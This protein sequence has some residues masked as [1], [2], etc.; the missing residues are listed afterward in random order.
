MR[1]LSIGLKS[2]FPNGQC[3]GQ[4][5]RASHIIPLAC[6]PVSSEM[7]YYFAQ[8]AAAT[9]LHSNDLWVEMTVENAQ[10]WWRAFLLERL[11]RTEAFNRGREQCHTLMKH[12]FKNS[13][14]QVFP[15]SV[16]MIYSNVKA[17]MHE[18]T[19]ACTI[20]IHNCLSGAATGVQVHIFISQ[21]AA[22]TILHLFLVIWFVAKYIFCKFYT[23]NTR[24]VIIP[25]VNKN[26]CFQNVWFACPLFSI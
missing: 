11:N 7:L 8:R 12:T 14:S 9:P 5:W 6:C 26:N 15:I 25:F 16:V 22:R 21:M 1:Q 20:T 17:D 18:V 23:S 2:Q 10:Y 19:P 24:G 13:N 3:W 4:L